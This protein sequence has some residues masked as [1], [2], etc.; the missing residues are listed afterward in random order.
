M[1]I[2]C[3]LGMKLTVVSA[4]KQARKFCIHDTSHQ[5]TKV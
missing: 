2:S 5:T 3:P 1:F 4:Y